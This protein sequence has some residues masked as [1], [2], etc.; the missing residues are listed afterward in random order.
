MEQLYGDD[1]S[2][3]SPSHYRRKY[4]NSMNQYGVAVGDN[5]F[6]VA[7][8]VPLILA[9][10]SSSKPMSMKP[11]QQ[12]N[13]NTEMN[14]QEES[15]Q[16]GSPSWYENMNSKLNA[17]SQEAF[18]FMH[19]GLS[20]IS[21]FDSLRIPTEMKRENLTKLFNRFQD[22]SKTMLNQAP[23]SLRDEARQ[24]LG[25]FMQQSAITMVPSPILLDEHA[26]MGYYRSVFFNTSRI[27][28]QGTG[29]VVLPQIKP[30]STWVATGFALNAKSGLAI[31]RPIRLPTNQGL[32][33]LGNC[34][35]QVRVG[36]R[37]LL[38]YGINNYLGKDLSNVILRIRASADFELFEESNLDRAVSSK[39]KDYTVTIPTFKSLA[40][41]TRSMV[42]VPKRNGVLQIVIEVE[43][44]FGGDYEVLTVFVSESGIER[45]QVSLRLF[46]LTDGTKPA[47][48]V[49]KIS[50]SPALRSVLLTVSGKYL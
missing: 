2:Q 35:K 46:D 41:E 1:Q 9:G 14:P 4:Q 42:F 13:G 18:I 28:S 11:E 25:E 30:Y 48:M 31:A 39:D 32:Y 49:E 17:I 5:D 7:T 34:P 36:E 12:Q 27:E 6:I 43:S 15:W 47:P 26:R 40:V 45:K 10:A 33:V 50:D 20:I 22:Q 19:S 23:F 16:Y 29:K 3:P 8:S 21:D 44:E 37:A 38:T 24:V